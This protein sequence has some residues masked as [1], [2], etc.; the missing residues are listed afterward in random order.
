MPQSSVTTW[1]DLLVASVQNLWATFFEFVPRFLGAVIVFVIGWVIASALGNVARRVVEFTQIDRVV[2]KLNIHKVFERADVELSI[3]KLIGWL[4]RWFLI[5]AFLIAAADIL[6]WQQVT[7]FLRE[8]ALYIPQVFV[9]VII[10]V[11][12]MVAADFVHRVVA[13]AVR[14]TGLL[15]PHFVAGVAKWAILV[16]SVLVALDQLD[17]GRTLLNTLVQGFVATIAI[18]AGLAFGLGGKEHAAKF[19]DR[20]RKDLSG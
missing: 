2:E 14:T 12:G 15:S 3:A 18:A 10:L 4:V 19:L 11:A 6:G 5:V 13:N 8:V 17:I 9:A 1:V 7:E 16:F 20:L